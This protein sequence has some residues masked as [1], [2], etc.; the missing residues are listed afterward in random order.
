MI[1]EV[2]YLI[3]IDLLAVEGL[4]D[5]RLTLQKGILEGQGLQGEDHQGKALQGEDHQGKA[6]QGKAL[7]YGVLKLQTRNLSVKEKILSLQTKMFNL[8]TRMFN[9]QTFTLIHQM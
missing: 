3:G 1:I 6:L 2:V 7:Q 8:Q 9:L 4:M 5:H